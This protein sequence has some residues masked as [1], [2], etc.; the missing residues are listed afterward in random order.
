MTLQKIP[1]FH[2]ALS[3]VR[4]FIV[5]HI[6][7]IPYVVGRIAHLELEHPLCLIKQVKPSRLDGDLPKDG[8]AK[9]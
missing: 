2:F 5:P 8:F 4:S 6:V 3:F 1:V 7:H 9:Y